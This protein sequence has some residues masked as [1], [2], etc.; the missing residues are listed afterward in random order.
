MSVNNPQSRSKVL[1]IVE[2]LKL[3][4]PFRL[5]NPT[6]R[7]T[8]KRCNPIKQARLDYFLISETLTHMLQNRHI[9]PGYRSDHSRVDIDIILD[10]FKLGKGVWK[11]NCS[12]LTHPDYVKLINDAIMTVK[13]QYAVPVYGLL[14]T[15]L[16]KMRGDTI[17]YASKLKK[18]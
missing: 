11:F 2:N 1:E 18:E 15:L 14:E 10:T 17:K 12:L 3:S 5:L 6:K 7:Y 4:D 16:L 8:W 13:K 9:K